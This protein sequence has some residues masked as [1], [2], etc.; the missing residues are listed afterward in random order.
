MEKIKPEAIR[1]M[2]G[3]NQKEF[4]K[5]LGLTV[6]TYHYRISGRTQWKGCEL[7]IMSEI[8]GVPI[9]KIDF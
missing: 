9:D 1:I 3:M 8:S 5:V 6:R 7:T 2:L 4:S